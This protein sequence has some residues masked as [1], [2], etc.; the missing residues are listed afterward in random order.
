[1][2]NWLICLL[3]LRQQKLS[4]IKPHANLR[5]CANSVNCCIKI[6]NTLF[7]SFSANFFQRVKV[8]FI[9][10]FNLQISATYWGYRNFLQVS[11]LKISSQFSV[12]HQNGLLG[13]IFPGVSL[14]IHERLHILACCSDNFHGGLFFVIYILKCL[15]Y[16]FKLLCELEIFDYNLLHSPNSPPPLNTPLISCLTVI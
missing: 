9:L 5:Y 14:L 10:I 7:L 12:A 16:S 3:S 4:K 2:F 1:M 13:S 6:Q 11:Q 8:V 15:N